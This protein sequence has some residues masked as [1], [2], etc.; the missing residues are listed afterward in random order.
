MQGRPA[1]TPLQKPPNLFFSS[2]LNKLLLALLILLLTPLFLPAHAQDP[3]PTLVPPTLVPQASDAVTDALPSES[4]IAQILRSGVV[5]VGILFNESPFGVLDVRGNVSGFDADLARSMGEL[6]GVTVEFVQVTRQTA[7]ATLVAGDVEMLLAALPHTR[8]LDAVVEFSDTYYPTAQAMLVREGDGAAALTDMANRRIGIVAGTRAQEAIIEWQMRSGITFTPQAYLTLDQAITALVNSEIDGVVANRI[9]LQRTVTQP[10][11]ARLLDQPV[12]PEPYAVAVRRQDVNLRN[13]VNRTLQFLEANGRL[14]EIHQANFNGAAYPSEWLPRWENVG[15]EAPRPDQFGQD[16][17]F[18]QQYAIPRIQAAGTVRVAGVRDLPADAPES[19]RRLDAANRA[20]IEALAARWRVTVTYVPG[21]DALGLVA[22]G[23]ADLA[24]GVVADW[25]AAGAVDFTGTYFQRGTVMMVPANSAFGG[26]GDLRGRIV[27]VFADEPG[28]AER[29]VE[30]AE[31]E[32]AI[33][34]GT[35][36]I[37]REQDAAFGMLADN[38][39]NAVFGDSLRIIPLLQA[40]PNDLRLWT[41]ADGSTRWFSRTYFH[42]AVP[43]NDIDFRL[44]VEYTL[45]ELSLDGGLAAAV[46]NATIPGDALLI[47]I[48]PG[49]RDY[50]GYNLGNQG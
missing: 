10:G 15:D 7:V 27:G 43:R 22:S 5:R 29:V 42:L 16:I 1:E 20:V 9:R 13:L 18:P 17:P 8:A 4:G 2:L 34:R 41:R 35:F 40:Q 26:F 50:L 33:L 46:A 30:L 38:N 32:R 23:A 24:V 49:S 25:N 44:L 28:A 31:A 14:N 39:Y 21:D 3:A 37:L 6:W 45:Q 36:S 48:W 19:A 12:M 11:I 47:D